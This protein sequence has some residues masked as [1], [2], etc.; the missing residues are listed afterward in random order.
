MFTESLE[1]PGFPGSPGTSGSL[2]HPELLIPGV[3]RNSWFPELPGTSCSRCHPEDCVFPQ[4]P[5][6]PRSRFTQNS[7]S[8]SHTEFFRFPGFI[9]IFSRSRIHSEHQVTLVTRYSGFPV[10]SGTPGPH[11][12]AEI[13]VLGSL[14]RL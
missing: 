12:H 11:C 9:R 6:N 1:D 14:I 5:G 3:T 2:S 8:S 10:S 13:R 7:C 4:A